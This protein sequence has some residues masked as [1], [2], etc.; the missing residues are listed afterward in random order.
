V[1]SITKVVFYIDNNRTVNASKPA[2]E[3]TQ[4]LHSMADS[5]KYHL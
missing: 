3:E 2:C 5:G 1:V 4:L